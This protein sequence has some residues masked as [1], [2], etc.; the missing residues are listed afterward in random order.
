MRLM[1]LLM[2]LVGALASTAAHAIKLTDADLA[3]LPE[4][5]TARLK[6]TGEYNLWV[7]RLGRDF[8]HTHHYCFGLNDLNR[9]YES[10][11]ARDKKFNLKNAVG[12]FTYM[13]THANQ[14]YSLMP[15]VY[16]NRGLAF[17]LMKRN[18]EAVQDMNKALELNPNLVKAYSYL[19]DFYSGINLK[20]RALRVIADGL[21]HNP[22]TT[23]LQRRYRELGGKLPYPEPIQPAPAVAVQ[24]ATPEA[25]PPPVQAEVAGEPA[26]AT[27]APAPDTPSESKIG[28]P[29]NPYCRFCPD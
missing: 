26:T 20:D 6:N 25:V 3:R 5:C 18:A 14:T 29:K 24:P 9:Y 13:V 21:R 19:A 2:V 16:M 7:Q 4:Y 23:S 11:T 28:S 10:R 8:D 17:S 15:E 1:G 27:V 22:D 12:N